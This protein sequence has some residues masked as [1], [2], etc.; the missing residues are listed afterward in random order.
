MFGPTSSGR[1]PQ[2]KLRSL[3]R[4]DRNE[5]E[6]VGEVELAVASGPTGV[7]A[8][9]TL[10]CD[11][12]PLRPTRDL[13]ALTVTPTGQPIAMSEP[14]LTP[15][16]KSTLIKAG[17]GLGAVV[18]AGPQILAMLF[19]LLFLGLFAAVA[20]IALAGTLL[21]YAL[22]GTC[23]VVG[24]AVLARLLRGPRPTAKRPPSVE[25]TQRQA[26]RRERLS[27][28]KLDLELLKATRD[29]QKR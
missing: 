10:D 28:A 8:E 25:E 2:A 22:L 9:R 1:V 7:G 14:L 3:N 24:I 29:A 18:W 11:E 21:K 23:G 5:G 13:F 20:A 15:K 26:S 12:V 16:E 4:P 19:V 27:K 17:L 6:F